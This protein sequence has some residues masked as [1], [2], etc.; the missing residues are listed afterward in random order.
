[1]QMTGNHSADSK[2]GAG[3]NNSETELR[4]LPI[5]I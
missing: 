1:M 4:Q 3:V 2:D 5:T